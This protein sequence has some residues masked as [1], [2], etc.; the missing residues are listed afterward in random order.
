MKLEKEEYKKYHAPV[1]LFLGYIVGLLA[2]VVGAD[3]FRRFLMDAD[4]G[5][6]IFNDIVR[7]VVFLV[8]YAI[9]GLFICWPFTFIFGY[10]PKK[11]YR[12]IAFYRFMNIMAI[13]APITIV[14][15]VILGIS[16]AITINFHTL[17]NLIALVL[18]VLTP[19]YLRFVCYNKF[20]IRKC[21]DCG[22]VNTMKQGSSSE[23]EIG[24]RME[25]YD[26]G[27]MFRYKPVAYKYSERE[28]TTSFTCSICGGYDFDYSTYDK[29]V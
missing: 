23:R 12:G 2:F 24:T 28:T 3:L 7:I 13:I 15:V 20:F 9:V 27:S 6:W 10:F 25:V 29:R 26:D 11:I 4:I 17:F 8:A 16:G 22:L 1:S 19:C 18:E 14:V 21:P 5:L